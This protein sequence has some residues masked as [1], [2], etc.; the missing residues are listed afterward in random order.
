MRI[1]RRS[2]VMGVVALVVAGG[3]GWVGV[4]IQRGLTV[5]HAQVMRQNA[6][7]LVESYI[8]KSGGQWPSKWDDLI[9]ADTP[10]P[11]DVNPQLIG[12]I[13][14]HVE[15]DFHVTVCDVAKQSPTEFTA[16]RYRDSRLDGSKCKEDNAMLI[17]TARRFCRKGELNDSTR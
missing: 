10:L 8:D 7:F 1:G 5:S 4:I 16:I 14:K 9:I 15:I 6:I 12:N 13:Q 17:A 3:V 2:V 11:L